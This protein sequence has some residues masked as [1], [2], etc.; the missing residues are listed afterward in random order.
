ME[1]DGRGHSPGKGHQHRAETQEERP[2]NAGENAP[3]GHRIRGDL[4]EKAPT[5]RSPA[6]PEQEGKDDK[7]RQAVDQGRQAEQPENAGLSPPPT[8]RQRGP[9]PAPEQIASTPLSKALYLLFV[10]LRHAL[11]AACSSSP[12]CHLPPPIHLSLLTPHASPLTF[13]KALPPRPAYASG[14]CARPPG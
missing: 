1:V 10:G 12:G 11:N 8:G 6:M 14:Q 7:Q 3:F 5:Q 2:H 13:P 4:R 9:D